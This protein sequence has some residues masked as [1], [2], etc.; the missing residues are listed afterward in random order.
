IGAAAAEVLQAAYDTADVFVLPSRYEGYGMVFAEAMAHGLPV[1]C[2]DI[3]AAREVVPEVAGL[4]APP[5]DAAALA[6]L[7]RALLGDQNRRA[8]IAQA[9]HAHAAAQPGWDATAR[10]IRDALAPL[11]GRAAA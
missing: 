6:A 5:N 2:A 8:A 10:I 9:A 3:D 4:R 1:V 7:L 11:A